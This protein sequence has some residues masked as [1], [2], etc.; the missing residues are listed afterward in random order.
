MAIHRPGIQSRRRP[1]SEPP[2]RKSRLAP[3]PAWFLPPIITSRAL[4]V[5]EPGRN[6]LYFLKRHWQR[7]ENT[8]PIWNL[9][10][11]ES[12]AS[13]PL[14]FSLQLFFF[15]LITAP[16]STVSWLLSV[17]TKKP[18][19]FR[20][21]RSWSRLLIGNFFFI[22]SFC[23]TIT[24]P[25]HDQSRFY[26]PKKKDWIQYDCPTCKMLWR[27]RPPRSGDIGTV[28]NFL[29]SNT[30]YRTQFSDQ[31]TIDHSIEYGLFSRYRL[32]LFT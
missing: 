11:L 27:V 10:R 19:R 32:N 22:L 17:L 31:F 9:P 16:Q 24:L 3:L 4:I 29:T 2:K 20:R 28:A 14:H 7:F 26:R 21:K 8:G 23:P 13:F 18:A 30:S 5:F 6:C 15:G 12:F 1:D 25:L